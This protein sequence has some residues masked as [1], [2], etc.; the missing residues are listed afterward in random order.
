[1]PFPPP[2]PDRVRLAGIDGPAMEVP[3]GRPKGARSL[4]PMLIK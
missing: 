3:A 2:T 4:F 1:M